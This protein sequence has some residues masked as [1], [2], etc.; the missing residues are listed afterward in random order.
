MKGFV[1]GSLLRITQGFRNVGPHMYDS[2][3]ACL[4]P[5]LGSLLIFGPLSP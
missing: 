4:A 3:E 5:G 2:L 1:R